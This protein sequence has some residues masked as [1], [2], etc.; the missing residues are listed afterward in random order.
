MPIREIILKRAAEQFF[1]RGYSR[2][3]TQEIAARAGISKKTLY[4][5]FGSKHELLR[6]V[7]HLQMEEMR[8]RLEAVFDE[9]ALDFITRT[10]KL[11]EMINDLFS[12]VGSG[13][14]QDIYRFAPELWQEIDDFRRRHF[15]QRLEQH[16]L[17]GHAR[18]LIRADIDPDLVVRVL[19]HNI[20]HLVAP[21][22][23]IGLSVT[24]QE[25]LGS[26]IKMLFTG[27]LADPARAAFFTDLP[28]IPSH[29]ETNHE[30]A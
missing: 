7:M 5:H 20:Q 17:R 21:E 18:G 27:I 30:N 25:M 23:L 9:P 8:L 10:R 1:S 4:R 22:Q 26:L 15:F 28:N 14:I 11:L 16:I 3:T 29:E 13:L 19:L 6:Q 12:R 24:A 2:V